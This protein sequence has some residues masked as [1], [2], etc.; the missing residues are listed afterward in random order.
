MCF[1]FS[2][3]VFCSLPIEIK[4]Q[5]LPQNLQESRVFKRS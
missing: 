3:E 5:V 4:W 2:H 1:G